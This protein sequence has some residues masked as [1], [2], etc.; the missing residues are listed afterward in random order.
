MDSNQGPSACKADALNRLSYA[1][2]IEGAKVMIISRHPNVNQGFCNFI[3]KQI[4]LKQ[5]AARL[6]RMESKK[7]S[8]GP[9]KLMN[10]YHRI[11]V[12]QDTLLCYQV[13]RM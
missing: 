4:P 1:P 9:V 5:T 2:L 3:E 10:T 7:T 6:F 8:D 13:Y 11:D 12:H